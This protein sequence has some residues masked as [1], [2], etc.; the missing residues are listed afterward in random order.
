[1]KIHQ[2]LEIDFPPYTKTFPAGKVKITFS[3]DFAGK[4]NVT[5]GQGH[6]GATSRNVMENTG[7]DENGIRGNFLPW[8]M[9]TAR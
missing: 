1:M 6:C 3:P 5:Q 2:N 7:E 9:M 4:T 8:K